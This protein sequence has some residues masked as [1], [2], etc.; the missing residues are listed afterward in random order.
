MSDAIAGPGMI[1][2]QFLHVFALSFARLR[3][4]RLLWANFFL[5]A[6]PVGIALILLVAPPRVMPSIGQANQIFDSIILKMLYFPLCVY[7]VANIIGFSLV[8]SESED[9]TLHY[10][11]L[12]PID[13]WVL[14]LGK[15]A[16]YL[17]ITSI[18]C[19]A[20]VWIT[21]LT[22]VLPRFSL[23]EV[24]GELLR[25]GRLGDMLIESGVLVLGL[26]AYGS[27]ALFMG[28]VFR[29]F[30]YMLLLLGW[31][32]IISFLP[33]QLKLW[34]V[35]FYLRSLMPGRPMTGDGIFQVIAEPASAAR[36]LT[37]L[38]AMTVIS[39][40]AA[41]ALFRNRECLYKES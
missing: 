8:R 11:L 10:L 17:V 6:I 23:E 15:F 40:G 19:V 13:R 36:S 31:E 28:T 2:A 25:A 29:S 33:A 20:S 3:R 39:I 41:I 16:A 38:I 12:Q 7:F 37:T 9:R 27:L 18:T 35:I 32:S 22:I 5:A 14:V 26:A 24:T 34:T 21:W 30:L 1:P 4:S